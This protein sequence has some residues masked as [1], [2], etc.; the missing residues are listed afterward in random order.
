MSWVFDEEVLAV[1]AA[2][3]VIAIV[4]AVSQALYAGRV[5]EP[6][7]ELGLLGSSGKIG[8]YPRNVAMGLPFQLNI[9]VGNHEGKV[10]YYRVL[11]KVGDKSSI[12]NASTPLSTEPIMDVRVVLEHNS[13]RIIPINIT[14]YEPMI[15]ARLVF[16]MWIYDEV[17][18]VFKYHGRWNQL[19]INVTENAAPTSSQGHSRVLSLSPSIESKVAEAYAAV[20]RAEEA[21]GDIRE[22]STLL[23]SAIEAA[24][25]GDLYV[26]EKLLETV[27]SLE[28][29]VV[30]AGIEL[31]RLKLYTTVIGLV[32][33]SSTCIGLYLYLRSNIWLLWAKAHK[34]WRVI[35]YGKNEGKRNDQKGNGKSSTNLDHRR[36]LSVADMISGPMAL[37]SDP[38]A[39][40]KELH[41]MVKAGVAKIYDPSPP[42]AFSSFLISRY[43]ASFILASLALALGIICIYISES[44]RVSVAASRFHPL[45]Y[46]LSAAIMLM[47][48]ALGSIIVLFLPGYS[49]VE[50][51]Y[52]G[53][54]EL[55]PLERLALSIGLSLALVPLIGLILNYTPWGIRL[56]PTII[57]TTL[58][59]VILLLASA[60]RKFMLLRSRASASH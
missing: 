39:A 23:N 59:I 9:Y 53:E 52:P 57:A 6:F 2:I 13:S 8:D 24:S 3:A 31:S 50:A 42:R 49:L 21:G 19:W 36:H 28:P 40:A 48:Y 5:V 58:L 46:P 32:I 35:W 20:R 51:L 60:Y 41:R 45:L 33:A 7:S 15:N 55:S 37:N 22:M 10:M 38:R 11:V 17:A 29:K 1:L 16:E 4:F 26:A 47:R 56:N 30:E 43:N 25:R 12:V 34:K 54:G 44:L 14:L 18:G 27:L